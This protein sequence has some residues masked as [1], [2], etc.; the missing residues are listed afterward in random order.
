MIEQIL[1]IEAEC[2]IPGLSNPD[3]FLNV[4]V[5]VPTSWPID[6]AEAKRPQLSRP[7]VLQHDPAVC[8][9]ERRG[10]AEPLED[11]RNF[12]ARGV[13]DPLVPL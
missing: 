12:G 9:G 13:R 2:H 4:R 5:E 3:S 7:G 11:L 6:R 8:I 10:G 1:R